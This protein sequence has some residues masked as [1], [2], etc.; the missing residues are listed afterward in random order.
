MSAPR[1]RP[2][3]DPVAVGKAIGRVLE[4][5]GLDASTQPVLRLAERWEEIVG[6]E[7]ARHA[8]PA[9]LRGR[10]LEIEVTS[11]VYGQELGLRRREILAALVRALGSSDAPGELRF[12]VASWRA[13]DERRSPAPPDER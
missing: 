11:P 5:L 6:P 13:R 10:T 1:T 9:A 2:K 8:R 3:R 12:R 4:D 7:V